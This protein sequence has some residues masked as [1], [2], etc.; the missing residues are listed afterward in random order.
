MHRKYRNKNMYVHVQRPWMPTPIVQTNISLTQ[1]ALEYEETV[2]TGR[3]N[4]TR[5]KFHSTKRFN[6]RLGFCC[7][8][9]KSREFIDR[10]QNILHCVPLGT[11]LETMNF[12]NTV[13]A[14]EYNVLQQTHNLGNPCPSVY[15]WQTVVHADSATI[16]VFWQLPTHSLSLIIEN[17]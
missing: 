11:T 15:Q 10:K 13:P 17:Y 8:H 3:L 16:F 6:F 5:T 9:W 7:A 2:W 4:D 1:W 14:N 12:D